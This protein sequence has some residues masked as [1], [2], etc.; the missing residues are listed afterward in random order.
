M[1]AC[2]NCGGFISTAYERVFAPT[3]NGVESCPSC[4]TMAGSAEHNKAALRE[5]RAEDA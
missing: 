2:R 4:A 1:P 3:P 5:S